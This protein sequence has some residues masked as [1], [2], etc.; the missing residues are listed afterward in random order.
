MASQDHSSAT[1]KAKHSA[2]HLEVPG[3]ERAD[4]SVDPDAERK[5]MISITLDDVPDH[6]DLTDENKALIRMA[7]NRHLHCTLAKDVTVATERD[8]YLALAHTVKDHVMNAWIKTQ[9]EYY[10]TDPKVRCLR[11]RAPPKQLHPAKC[12]ETSESA[13]LARYISSTHC[14]T[15]FVP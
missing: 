15:V 2:P 4:S 14:L 9:Q 6:D 5:R 13:F 12:L 10:K 11:S 1:T 8:Y 7:F 3:L